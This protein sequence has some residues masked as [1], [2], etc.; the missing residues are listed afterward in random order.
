MPV[1]KE[2]HAMWCVLVRSS[3]PAPWFVWD[4]QAHA[5]APT[6]QGTKVVQAHERK[7]VLS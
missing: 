1:K 2:R 6:M 5:K 7:V 3:N 4:S